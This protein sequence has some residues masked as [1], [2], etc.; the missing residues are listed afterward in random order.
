MVFV[1]MRWS[2][3]L[4]TIRSRVEF[5]GTGV[6]FG[7]IHFVLKFGVITK[8]VGVITKLVNKITP[9]RIAQSDRALDLKT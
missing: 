2:A 7:I 5:L 4:A 9:A 3:S 1:V 8:L 6:K